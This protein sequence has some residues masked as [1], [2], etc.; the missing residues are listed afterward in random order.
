MFLTGF[1]SLTFILFP[2]KD[3]VD[4]LEPYALLSDYSQMQTP[5]E[6]GVCCGP[7][8]SGQNLGFGVTDPSLCPGPSIICVP[9][10][11]HHS[12]LM[13]VF[14]ILKLEVIVSLLQRVWGKVIIIA[15]NSRVRY[16]LSIVLVCIHYVTESLPQTYKIYRTLDL[17][18]LTSRVSSEK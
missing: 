11:G 4:F 12:S 13:S 15:I 6:I 17:V 14:S 9:W 10:A 5:R 3:K 16:Y 1:V 18:L 2:T 7:E 8:Y